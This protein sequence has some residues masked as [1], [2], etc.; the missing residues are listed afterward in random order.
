MVKGLS[1][2]LL[3]LSLL[4][5]EPALTGPVAAA[6]AP[7]HPSVARIYFGV[8]EPPVVA[9]Q[10]I[11]VRAPTSNQQLQERPL[12]CSSL[13]WSNGHLLISSDRHNHLV[14]RCPVDLNRMTIG[15]LTPHVVIYNE[16]DVIE[17]GECLAVQ[18]DPQGETD[19]YMLSSL[20][21]DASE[22]PLP[23][24]RQMLR[25]TLQSIDPFRIK[26]SVVLNAGP[27]R[28][29][30]NDL[31]QK[32]GIDPYRTFSLDLEKNTYRWG[33]VEGLCFAPGGSTALLGMRNPL[34]RDQAL[35]A[36]VQGLPAA[37]DTRDPG[38]FQLSD[39]V[40][41][42]LGS[43][44]ISDLCWD[45]VTRGYILTA[46]R[47]SGPKLNKDQPFP[48]NT[49]DS[50]LFWWSGNKQD[51]PLLFATFED[52]KIEAVC[53]LGDS[54]YLAVGSDEADLSEARVQQQQSILTILYF[55]GM[56]NE[57]SP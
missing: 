1:Y 16:H 43:R 55:T 35:I 52:L 47:S 25:V 48:P 18:Q 17:D 40:T 5:F 31:F 30:V 39:L 8:M 51:R 56:E 33:N 36:V 4:V 21:N 24:R 13:V 53:R 15:P 50:A 20:S 26:Q 11:T 49:L 44:G 45:P 57:A 54:A 3:P 37:F 34:C 14:F 32:L 6:G 7:R 27:I 29:A 46:A 2:M 42:D 19:L 23:K 10:D 9:Q 41:L 12:E 38:R 22:L 28:D